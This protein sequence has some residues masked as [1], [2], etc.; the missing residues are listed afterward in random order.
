MKKILATLFIFISIQSFSAEWELNPLSGFRHSLQL[1]ARFS[2]VSD[3]I[4]NKFALDYFTNKFITTD[5]KDEVSK[6]LSAK[7]KLGIGFNSEIQ[8]ASYDDTIF[9]L[10]HSF[11]SVAIRNNYHINGRFSR[12]AFEL[13]FR[14]NKSYAGKNADLS[15]FLFNQIAYQQFNFTFGHEYKYELNKFGWN[16]GL[17]LNK[18]QDFN[19]IEVKR[20]H[21]FTAEDGEYIDLDA[22]IDLNRSDS[23]ANTLLSW[24][25]TGASIDG[26]FY[27]KNKKNN[28]V[29]LFISNAGFIKW[30]NNSSFVHADT[31]F[32]FEGIDVSDIFL[33]SDTIRD[34]ISLDSSLVE[35]Y[36]TARLKRSH[37]TK[38]PGFIGVSYLYNLKPEKLSIEAGINYL[39]FAD[40]DLLETIRLVYTL[41][42]QQQIGLIAS[43]GGYGEFRAGISFT[44]TL[45]KRWQLS[46]ESDCLSSTFSSNG[47]A[48]GAFV[49]LSAH[50]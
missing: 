9:G 36:L 8:Y 30:N 45:F 28:K 39:F 14:G 16:T 24:K 40:A 19:L 32:R 22:D 46:L 50:F 10:K 13:Y 48:Q 3:A 49:S 12:D 42:A 6:N 47:R 27:W 21:I 41:H 15:D 4:T 33:L 25:G 7:N 31:S 17:S 35:P 1:S 2:F 18:G 34:P 37:T 44:T 5:R 38:L 26:Q 29:T 20:A 11:Y 43:N 23:S